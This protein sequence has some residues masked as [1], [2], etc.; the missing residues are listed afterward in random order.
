MDL[1]VTKARF[2]EEIVHASKRESDS[3]ST[4]FRGVSICIN[5]QL[6]S[7]LRFQGVVSQSRGNNNQTLK[8][9]NGL[10]ELVRLIV[11]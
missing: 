6:S 10:F 3:G 9:P 11:H 1:D 2:L 8:I 7:L 5:V 4:E